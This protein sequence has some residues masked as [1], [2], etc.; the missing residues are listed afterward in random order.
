M[1][2]PITDAM[3]AHPLLFIINKEAPSHKL[4]DIYFK[5]VHNLKNLIKFPMFKKKKSVIEEK[6]V[7]HEYVFNEL[8]YGGPQFI[9]LQQLYTIA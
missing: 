4:F 8:I 6:E 3:K 2:H 7:V 1:F 9:L 5:I